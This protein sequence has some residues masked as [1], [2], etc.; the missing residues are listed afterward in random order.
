MIGL[1]FLAWSCWCDT[2]LFDN[3]VFSKD[4]SYIK[5]KSYP[6][7]YVFTVPLLEGGGKILL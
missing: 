4:D 2:I 1:D 3:R 5:E 7:S 6:W